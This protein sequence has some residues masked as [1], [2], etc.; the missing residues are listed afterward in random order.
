MKAI[1]IIGVL[2]G[3]VV[4]GLIMNVSELILNV[5]VAG[6]RMEAELKAINLPPPGGGAIALFSLTTLALGILLIWLYAAI[7]PRF[8]AGPKTAIC[9]GLLVWTLSYL[10]ASVFFG[11]L[12]VNSWGLIALGLVWS[13]VECVLA[14]LSGA[15][16]Y[17]E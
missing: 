14:A 8:G 6:A 3:G 1:N 16:L 9:A 17:S 11:G 13:L 2:K 5:P 12:G 10:Y 4:A 15:Y 7:R